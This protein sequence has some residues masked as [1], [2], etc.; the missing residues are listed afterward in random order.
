MQAWFRPI[1]LVRL[2]DSGNDTPSVP[3]TKPHHPFRIT[4]TLIVAGRGAK[5]SG[6]GFPVA[7]T[8]KLVAKTEEA[9]LPVHHRHPTHRK[10]RRI[11]ELS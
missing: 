8:A 4:A 9:N 10:K 1:A 5:T 2:L 11:Q 7:I 3:K 6:A